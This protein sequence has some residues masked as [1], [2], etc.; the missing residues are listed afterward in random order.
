MHTL[1]TVLVLADILSLIMGCLLTYPTKYNSIGLCANPTRCGTSRSS[2]FGQEYD[3]DTKARYLKS[4]LTTAGI[5]LRTL[6][7]TIPIFAKLG[8][9]G[10]TGNN[11]L[12]KRRLVSDD[13]TV[14]IKR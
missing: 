12:E 10:M 1:L 13:G 2:V 4:F 11:L 9:S 5:M 14:S 6:K 7:Q 8:P 3:A